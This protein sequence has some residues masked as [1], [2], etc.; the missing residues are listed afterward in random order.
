M[1]THCNLDCMRSL[2]CNAGLVRWPQLAARGH[3]AQGQALERETSGQA[4][5]FNSEIELAVPLL[6][7]YENGGVWHT[8]YTGTAL[9]CM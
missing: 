8:I 6:S 9:A 5:R 1:C 2:R 4:T 3:T 7:N